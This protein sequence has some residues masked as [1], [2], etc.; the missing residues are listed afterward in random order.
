MCPQAWEDKAAKAQ[1]SLPELLRELEGHRRENANLE[2]E[3]AS[4]LQTNLSSSELQELNSIDG[5]VA[6]VK[7]VL[8][9]LSQAL[10]DKANER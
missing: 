4:P 7:K 2:E 6:K 3:M 9:Q 5:E 10:Q 1:E 8:K